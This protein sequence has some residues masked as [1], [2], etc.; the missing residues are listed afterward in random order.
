MTKT[1]LKTATAEAKN[2]TKTA[3]Q[4]VY[5]AL[6]SGQQKKPS[7]LYSTYT[8]WNTPVKEASRC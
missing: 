6:N 2:E 1:K 5:D 7:R 8:A 3:L 4:T